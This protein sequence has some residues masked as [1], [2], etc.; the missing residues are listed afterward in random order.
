MLHSEPLVPVGL[1]IIVISGLLILLPYLRGK[2][3]MITFWNLMLLGG[4]LFMGIGSLGVKYGRFHWKELQWFQPSRH[5][6]LLFIAGAIAF[7]AVLFV[8]Y[9]RLTWPQKLAS[10]VFQKWPP[11]STALV[12]WI[13]GV[14]LAL[15]VAALFTRHIVFVGTLLY[16]VSHKALVFAVVFS[17][18]HWYRHKLQL[19]MLAM[20][21]AVFLFAVLYAMVVFNGRRLLLSVVG[22][23][24]LCM[25]WLQWRY[26]SPKSNLIRLGVALSLA[27]FVAGFYSTFRHFSSSASFTSKRS[28]STTIDAMKSSSLHRTVKALTDNMYY[29]FSEYC[30]H[31][32]LLTI[33]LLDKH[34][35]EV[36]PL[37]S[38]KFLVA[39]PIPRAVW[40]DK[41]N[42]LGQSIVHDVLHMP[43]KTNWGLGIVGNGYREGGIPTI[44]LYAFLIVFGIRVMDDNLRRQPNNMFLLA[45][46]CAAAPHVVAWIRGEAIIM[47]IETGEA[48]AFAWLLGTTARFLFGTQRAPSQPGTPIVPAGPRYA[49]PGHAGR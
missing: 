12:F 31:Y 26:R 9:Y 40:H 15:A 1:A 48:F 16:N 5:D 19:P 4:A 18:C 34:Q 23:P 2:S 27:I 42:V 37:E 33:D 46:L 47:T 10:R 49:H 8:T 25:Y 45:I 29:Y 6:V 22:A 41:P 21:L 32:S 11:M 20:F 17:F 3:D 38:L 44:M 35:I 7:Y 43:Y 36:R 24:L 14:C 13:V 28:F 39:Y 30:V